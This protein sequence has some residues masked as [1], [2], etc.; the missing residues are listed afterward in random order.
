MPE[1]QTDEVSRPRR[2]V[3]PR[4]G[5]GIFDAALLG[6]TRPPNFFCV[7]SDWA[8][9]GCLSNWLALQGE[10]VRREIS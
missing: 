6:P 5:Y 8:A 3:T 2:I 4:S 1:G 7:L 9:A 10:L